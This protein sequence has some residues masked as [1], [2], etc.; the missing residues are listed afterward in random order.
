MK[1]ILAIAFTAIALSAP[2]VP[3]AHAAE[4][5]AN[6]KDAFDDAN[7]AALGIEFA[8]IDAPDD[9]VCSHAFLHLTTA[10]QRA[11]LRI[12]GRNGLDE[13]TLKNEM[14]GRYNIGCQSTQTTG[15]ASGR[16]SS[17]AAP[18]MDRRAAKRSRSWSPTSSAT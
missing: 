13:V 7:V 9:I 15:R 18:T 1:R 14:R 12:K 4:A 5:I 3:H 16:C 10:W 17:V 11:D 8:P 6:D 2:A